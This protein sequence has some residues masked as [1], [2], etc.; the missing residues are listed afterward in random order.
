M[1]IIVY[2]LLLLQWP[3]LQRSV[4]SHLSDYLYIKVI[5]LILAF[6]DTLVGNFIPPAG[7]LITKISL[8]Y[9]APFR[10]TRCFS[11]GIFFFFLEV[12]N[13]AKN[14]QHGVNLPSLKLSTCF[15]VTCAGNLV[16]ANRPCWL[17]RVSSRK[18]YLG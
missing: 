16:L 1:K 8:G 11:I 12:S 10:L 4:I 3:N 17:N 13:S 2:N 15:L 9:F 6:I 7:R 14:W 5:N 18:F